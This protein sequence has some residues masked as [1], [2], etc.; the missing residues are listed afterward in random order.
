MP[1]IIRGN[2]RRP[3]RIDAAGVVEVIDN[4]NRIAVVVT[5]SPSG[6]VQ[7]LTPGNILFKQYCDAVGG[8]ASK[9]HV[10]EDYA[11]KKG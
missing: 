10:H 3:H 8:V 7:I 9:V 5:Q 4:E 1:L 2:D 11:V 6:S